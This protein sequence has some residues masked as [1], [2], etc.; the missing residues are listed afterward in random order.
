LVAVPWGVP[1]YAA[2]FGEVR[3]SF[4]EGGYWH[5]SLVGGER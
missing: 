4:S 1:A 5:T 2:G 3:R